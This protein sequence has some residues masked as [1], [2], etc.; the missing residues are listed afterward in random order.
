M[1]GKFFG[2]SG[3]TA[4]DMTLNLD[5]GRLSQG[6]AQTRMRGG[7]KRNGAYFIEAPFQLNYLA[8]L[9]SSS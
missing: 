5:L 9:F 7:S 3:E 2:A 1:T 6:N 8:G 4:W